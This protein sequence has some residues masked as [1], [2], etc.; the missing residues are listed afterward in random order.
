MKTSGKIFLFVLIGLLAGGLFLMG[1]M[2]NREGASKEALPGLSVDVL[3]IGKADAIVIREDEGF[4]VIDAGEE[5]DGQEV[6]DFLVASGAESVK[7]LIITHY[8]KDHVGGADTLL[9]QIP[10]ERVLVPDYEGSITDYTEF[11]AAAEE[12]HAKH[13][14]K[15]QKVTEDIE[16]SLGSAD[17]YIE[18]PASYELPAGAVEADND[19]SLITTVTH[20]ENCLIFM[21]DAEKLRIREW[22]AKDNSRKCN[23]LKIPHHGVYTAAYAELMEATMPEYSAICTS[24]KN[25]ADTKSLE[26]FRAYGTT[27]FE[28]KDGDV[29]LVSDGVSLQANQ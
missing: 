12:A 28:T 14:T 7:A 16:F 21:G 9:E 22:L 5:E 2:R 6:V 25:P 19:F 15:L 29:T 1:S 10:V 3:K 23:F 8:D 17:F 13:G 24:Q 11:V 27:V 4:V 18:P 20:G 26:L